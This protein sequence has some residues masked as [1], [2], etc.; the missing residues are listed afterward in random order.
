M[1]TCEPEDVISKY[2]SHAL[3][4]LD[5]RLLFQAV[6]LKQ[7]HNVHCQGQ[8]STNDIEDEFAFISIRIFYRKFKSILLVKVSP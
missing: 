8:I 1:S 6:G 7:K 2:K 4:S 3:S 5:C